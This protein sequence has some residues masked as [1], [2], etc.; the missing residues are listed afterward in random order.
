VDRLSLWLAENVNWLR[1]QLTR[2]GRARED[3]EDL[4]Q[5]GI[6]RVYEY[7]ARGGEVREP[8]AVLVRTVFRLAQN[9]LRDSRCHLYSKR[10]LEDLAIVDPRARP[11]HQADIQQRLERV[12]RVLETVPA[13]SREVF[14]LHR[15]AGAGHEEIATRL[16]ISVSAVEKHVARAVAALV[17]E[18]LRE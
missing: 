12:M 15:L 4:I 13:R 10:V 7:Q 8:E 5:E 9:Q 18:K 6:V 3:A 11:E 16:G 14:L 1:N 17:A 2:R